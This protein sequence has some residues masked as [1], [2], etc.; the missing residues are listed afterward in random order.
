MCFRK[1]STTSASDQVSI[2]LR[3]LNDKAR[4]HICDWECPNN[5]TIVFKHSL[6]ERSVFPSAYTFDRLFDSECDT[7][8]VYEEGAKHIALLVLEGINSS[9]FAYGKT[10]SGKTY[11]MRSITE[12]AVS[13]I[14]D[15]I[16]NNGERDFLVKLCAM[17][18]YNEAV[19]DLISPDSYPLRVLDDPER[20]TIV[21]KLIEVTL[22]NREHLH[23]LLAICEENLL[24]YPPEHVIFGD[25]VYELCDEETIRKILGAPERDGGDLHCRPKR[26]PT[27]RGDERV[28][29]SSRR[30]GTEFGGL[31]VGDGSW[32]GA[33]SISGVGARQRQSERGKSPEQT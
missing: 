7:T 24:V 6:P 4:N 5:H 22:R 19:R 15:Y 12:Y 1:A 28:S 13:N 23:E 18:I 8:Q 30:I 10:S 2:R 32:E 11:T 26:G 21:E 27:M 9:I 3:P 16:E 14:Y 20:G 25:Y 33:G 31:T 29:H 17:E